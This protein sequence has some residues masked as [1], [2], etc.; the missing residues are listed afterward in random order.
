MGYQTFADSSADEGLMSPRHGRPT[1]LRRVARER[2]SN[3]SP[4][5]NLRLERKR[6]SGSVC[7]QSGELVGDCPHERERGSSGRFRSRE[8]HIAL[9]SPGA[10]SFG[11]LVA[12]RASA[13]MLVAPLILVAPGRRTRS[14]V[15]TSQAGGLP[16]V[17]RHRLP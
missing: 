2:R 14:V 12:V 10:V 3:R 4:P 13:W 17:D 16:E 8:A 5:R 9:I 7:E 15:L 11:V 1:C 6:C